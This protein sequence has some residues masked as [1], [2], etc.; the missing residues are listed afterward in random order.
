MKNKFYRL[1]LLVVILAISVFVIPVNAFAPL[2]RTSPQSTDSLPPILQD[3]TTCFS[4]QIVLIIDQS[5]SMVKNDSNGLRYYMPLYVAD[6]L[7]HNYITARST[8]TR[9]E[10]PIKTQLAVVQF[11]V[12][13][14]VGL[15]WTTIAP[16]NDAAWEEQRAQ[17]ASNSY[18]TE[19]QI[20]EIADELGNG[21]SHFAAFNKVGELLDRADPQEAGCPSRTYILL[22][23]GN[24]DYSGIPLQGSDLQEEMQKIQVTV[25]NRLLSEGST[26][27]VT[28]INDPSNYFWGATEKYWQ[29]ITH[30]E[31]R[32]DANEP[33][34]AEQVS[35]RTRAEIGYRLGQIINY[36]LGNGISV[37][38][39]GDHVVPP[40]LDRLVFT[41][42]KPDKEDIIQ[43]FDQ[44]GLEI[45]E[46][47]NV[48]VEGGDEGIQTITLLQPQP[49]VYRLATTA[50]SGEYFI[51]RNMMFI[52]PELESNINGVYQ[53]GSYNVN[54]SLV[55]SNG[56]PIPNYQDDKYRL[57]IEAEI[58]SDDS[59]ETIPVSLTHDM[60]AGE[61]T[62]SFVPLW[63][64][65]NHLSITAVA[66]DD[67]AQKW[68]VLVP[69]FADFDILV[70]PLGLEI[71]E[72][73]SI[74]NTN[75]R[76]SQFSE[77]QMP[78]YFSTPAIKDT[79]AI[80]SSVVEW[81][82]TG[83]AFRDIQVLGPDKDGKYEL[84]A[85]SDVA[86]EENLTIVASGV[87]PIDG[88]SLEIDTETILVP[89]EEGHK[90]EFSV[91]SINVEPGQL[92]IKLN[93]FKF[94][95]LGLS[96]P[97]KW[98]IGRRFFF[99]KPDI[100]FNANFSENNTFVNNAS[101]MPT[102][103]LKQQG[104]PSSAPLSV[105]PWEPV[106]GM[107]WNATYEKVPLG[108]YTLE[109]NPELPC[110]TELNIKELPTPICVVSD[111]SEW[112]II[113]VVAILLLVGL[114]F[115]IRYLLCR[116]WNPMY[117]FLAIID[118]N[119][120]T[121]WSHPLDGNSCWDFELNE[122]RTC[123]VARIKLCG[124]FRSGK[125]AK[126]KYYTRDLNTN[127]LKC[128]RTVNVQLGAPWQPIIF[129]VGC[130]IHWVQ[131]KQQLP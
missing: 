66:L 111:L 121:V 128:D 82:V 73:V 75:C 97:D 10:Q 56:D 85:T 12:N 117:G 123:M 33:E 48:I 94:K 67:A 4:S 55:D 118:Q 19:D 58:S 125:R 68:D 95:L 119:N 116:F 46:G 101:L 107:W 21:T 34:R 78:I 100:S 120:H 32:M 98:V 53:F 44:K 54:I 131:D 11:R 6:L 77:F 114:A 35:T 29:A 40:Y 62:G 106:N 71:G 69:P 22:T 88:K 7:A 115:L 14:V 63:P 47:P 92:L 130:R 112:I 2:P 57:N 110:G 49:G 41:F 96:E 126:L 64:G 3:Q 93:E 76:P 1:S 91:D 25:D 61:I 80:L 70:D 50:K 51:T 13:A 127:R 36:R 129:G 65:V 23:D 89:I 113:L 31:E 122:T 43:I 28:A 102:L 20:E 74:Q 79:S 5:I 27:Y 42:Y 104:A 8:A 24:P 18:L 99:V 86:G 9:L 37:V 39:V 83:D 87:N 81:Q 109:I 52:Q 15:D 103:E 38:P 17:I 84:T 59:G 60:L 105:S 30:N 45:I 124:V 108:C 26:L 16:E 72:P 90:Y